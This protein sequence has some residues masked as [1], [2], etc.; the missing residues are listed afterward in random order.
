VPGPHFFHSYT[1]RPDTIV[2]VLSG[3]GV[4]PGHTFE[5]GL[6]MGDQ[7][8]FVNSRLRKHDNREWQLASA[9]QS[10]MGYHGHCLNF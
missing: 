6:T 4:P 10:Q 3:S 2:A 8:P 9:L 1:G 5:I 7:K